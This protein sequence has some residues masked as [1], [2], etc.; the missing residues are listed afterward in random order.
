ML[1]LTRYLTGLKTATQALKNNV[2]QKTLEEDPFLFDQYIDQI[3]WQFDAKEKYLEQA[4]R[5]NKEQ[6]FNEIF[7]EF[8]KTWKALPPLI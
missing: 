2:L 5:E 6:E 4:R 7:S 8:D 3:E 1:N